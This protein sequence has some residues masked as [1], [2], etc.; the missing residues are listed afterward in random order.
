MT[1]LRALVVASSLSLLASLAAPSHA[2]TP[3]CAL[4]GPAGTATVMRV[5]LPAGAPSV[6]MRITTPTS[7]SA[8][9]PWVLGGRSSWHLATQVALI[10]ARDGR[11]VAHRELQLGSWPRR[12]ALSASGQS[13]HADAVGPGL[14]FKHT[15]GVVPD[16]LD[17]GSYLLVAFGSDG[18][19]ALPNPGWS[20]E[21][22]FGV[23]A[24]CLASTVG[25]HVFDADQTT[26]R[27][28]TQVSALGPGIGT[29][30]VWSAPLAH[31]LVLGMVD[32]QSQ[33]VG[34]ADVRVA[35]PRVPPFVVHDALR[36]F[37]GRAGRWRFEAQWQGAVPLVLVSGVTF[38]HP[39]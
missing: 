33:L 24:A 19:S 25:T 6:A 21:V 31:S 17:P 23:P 5:E 28:G 18:D 34:D 38:E 15:G 1:R 12:V 20:A 11:L 32:A 22:T 16:H 39:V 27:G 26:F 4:A 13:E 9:A 36:P 3:V 7:L 35:P 14:P 30:T 29:G 10:R 8:T 2:A 37:V